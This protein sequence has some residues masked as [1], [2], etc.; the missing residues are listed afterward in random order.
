MIS[1]IFR[2]GIG[3][4]VLWLAAAVASAQAPS[5]AERAS[6]RVDTSALIAD[7]AEFRELTIGE[8]ADVVPGF[9]ESETEDL[10]VQYLVELEPVLW[11]LDTAYDFQYF[12]TNNFF[13]VEPDSPLG[14]AS[15]TVMTHTVS[16]GLDYGPRQV[17]GGTLNGYI[18]LDYQRYLHGIG[19]DEDFEDFD[20]DVQTLFSELQYRF[21]GRW[22]ARAGVQYERLVA[23]RDSWDEFYYDLGPYASVE[24]T[25]SIGRNH[26]IVPSVSTFWRFTNV[27]SLGLQP[28]NVNDRVETTGALY[29]FFI[30]RELTVS[31][32]G[33]AEW[34]NY[35]QEPFANRDDLLFS[36]GG[37][38]SYR[39]REWLNLRFFG[40]YDARE[41]DEPLTT[42][43][44]KWDAGVALTARLRW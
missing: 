38:V 13:L 3:A 1:I 43:Y 35:T 9:L 18:G 17:P 15:T 33:R 10:G 44:R 19:A 20:F 28:I 42:D 31:A 7:E 2:L 5:A 30:W 34:S 21:A 16:L 6:A 26:F 23:F 40:L 32:F 29:Y 24:R 39:L 25:F 8:V 14:E 37:S 41:S 4:C 22:E 36:S 12:F 27:N 11:H